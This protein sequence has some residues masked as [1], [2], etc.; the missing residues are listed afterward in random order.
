MTA[1]TKALAVGSVPVTA[2]SRTP[3][4]GS[5]RVSQA[6]C[7]CEAGAGFRDAAEPESQAAA[8]ISSLQGAGL[9]RG[10]RRCPAVW[11]HVQGATAGAFPPVLLCI[12]KS[13]PC[14]ILPG[15][16]LMLELNPLQHAFISLVHVPP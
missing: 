14:S 10:S 7:R 5:D 13:A 2:Q 6:A 3:L 11:R 1:A 8:G 16:E 12:L 15:S 9:A 4:G